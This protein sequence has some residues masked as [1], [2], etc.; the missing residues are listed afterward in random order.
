MSRNN[1]RILLY[2]NILSPYRKHFFDLLKKECEKNG[3]EFRVFVMAYTEPNRKWVYD[4]FKETYT[5]LLKGKSINIK[6]AYI[7]INNKL[8][9]RLKDYN[10]DIVICSGSYLCPGIWTLANKKK[11]RGYKCLFWSESHINQKRNNNA[12]T[13]RILEALRSAVYKRFDAFLYAGELSFDFIKKYAGNEA[14][15]IF[16]PNL[17][18]EDKFSKAYLRDFEGKKKIRIEYNLPVDKRLMIM[19]ARLSR[20]KGIDCFLKLLTKCKGLE[21]VYVAVAGEGELYDELQKTI[22]K[23][24]LPVSLLGYKSESQMIDLYFAS[25]IFLLPSLSDPNPLSCIEALWCG[26]PL[27]ISNRVG[28]SKEVL[29]EGRNGYVFSYEKEDDAIKKIERMINAND[30]WLQ[31]AAKASRK[32]AESIYNSKKNVERIVQE[33]LAML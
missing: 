3:A 18:D 33:L 26:L 31:D 23:G 5:E 9:S 29:E 32:K 22:E 14:E 30:E 27:L 12:L 28:N 17:I 6:N 4:D 2:T 15:G 10:P 11:R 21:S 13:S 20:V 8:I 19:P 16:V 1:I 7:H 24:K 25:D